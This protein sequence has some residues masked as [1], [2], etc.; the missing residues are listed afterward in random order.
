MSN[1]GRPA[2]HGLNRKKSPNGAGGVDRRRGRDGVLIWWARV[3]LPNT[4]PLRR[5]RVPI[6]NSARMT[7]E[8]ARRAAEV[9]AEKV[10]NGQILFDGEPKAGE[11]RFPAGPG[12]DWHSVRL[13]GAAWT[14]GEMFKRFGK[15]SKLR[16][17]AGAYID[18]VTLGAHVYEVKTRGP[19]ALAF[20]DLDVAAV[21]SDDIA[22]VMGAQSA[23]HRAETRIKQYN[24]LH[25][26]FEL[27]EFP[28]RLR[29]EGTNPV[30]KYLRP[31]ADADKLFSFLFPSEALALLR[32]TNADGKIV[33]PLARR[34]L[35]A[36]AL[37]T[38]QRKGSLFALR[39]KHV[40]FDHGTLASFRTKTGAAQYFV[41][42]R[43][44]MAVLEAWHE[45]QGKP[46]DDVP[47]VSNAVDVLGC[48]PKRLAT[49]LRDDLKA[50][51]VTRAILFETEE[52]NVQELR[53]HDARATFCTWARRAGK[54][55]SWISERTGQKESGKM[56]DRY[57][58]GAQ[59]LAD[60][61]YEP[62]PDISDAIPELAAVRLA[63]ALAKRAEEA[64]EANDES[65]VLPPASLCRH[66][67]VRTSD[68]YRVKAICGVRARFQALRDPIISNSSRYEALPE[69]SGRDA[70]VGRKV[71]RVEQ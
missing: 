15:V 17:K 70:K 4:K 26:L 61:Q 50:C 14:S 12:S 5:K 2:T 45:H 21:T 69:R 58:R 3:S 32:G 71:G 22:K 63:T 31:E 1:G 39:W 66:D 35:Y 46:A 16:I 8:Q 23:D 57:D 51:G 33:I 52:E 13:L 19:S 41:A 29:P 68:P 9:I 53:F 10:R 36:L 64:A 40:D 18:K 60:L 67:W 28:C 48:E 42:D 34:V 38:G 62:F 27:A 20:G 54:S 44:L 30:K 11:A 7:E 55:D 25:R 49:T 59:T 24:R 43:G 37:Y 56:I 65:P 47:I 6:P